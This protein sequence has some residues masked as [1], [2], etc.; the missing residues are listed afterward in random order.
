MVDGVIPEP[1]GG[2][3]WDHDEAALMLKQ[4]I[5]QAINELKDIDPENRIDERI[6][7]FSRMG[8][9]EEQANQVS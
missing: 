3:H 9:W 1:I 7:K 6:E 4:Q 5:T 2:A 8:R